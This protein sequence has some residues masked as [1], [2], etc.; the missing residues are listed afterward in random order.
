M[1]SLMQ[2]QGLKEF[3]FAATG[4]NWFTASENTCSGAIDRER[5]GH[6]GGHYSGFVERR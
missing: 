1:V 5:G 2:E 3:A 6:S 4:E